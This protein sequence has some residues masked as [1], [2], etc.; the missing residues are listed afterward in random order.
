MVQSGSGKV[1]ACAAVT[2]AATKYPEY[3]DFFLNLGIAGA[4][5]PS[6]ELGSLF[7]VYKL[8]DFATERSY[9][10]D[11]I[12]ASPWKSASLLTVDRPYI[13]TLPGENLLVDMEGT[14]FFQAAA[15]FAETH[16]IQLLKV[17]SDYLEGTLCTKEEV[18]SYMEVHAPA[19][20]DW[21]EEKTIASE[22]KF[23]VDLEKQLD[24][25][26]ENLRLT[27]SQSQI[28]RNSLEA[29]IK[30]YK[31]IPE[32]PEG[33]LYREN[34]EKTKPSGKLRF[35]ALIRYLNL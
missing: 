30:F 21:L 19:I 33:I 5:N 27:K 28:L 23:S 4:S 20:L 3:A 25:I 9:Y 32:I 31:K 13:G 16:R 10:P 15:R 26:Q 11:I 8:T 2:Y 35:S 7:Q 29:Y 1:P 18:E 22:T 14:G 34:E 6:I 12:D 24:A 17:V